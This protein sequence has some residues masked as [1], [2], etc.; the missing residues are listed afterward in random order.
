MNEE[1]DI[2]ITSS[3]ILGN[4]AKSG[5][6]NDIT[7]N[8]E[9]E[10]II[11][12]FLIIEGDRSAD[13]IDNTDFQFSG[14]SLVGVISQ[15]IFN[16][17]GS[18]FVQNAD[19]AN[20]FA[21]TKTIDGVTSGVL[22]RNADGQFLVALNANEA[23]PALD[24]TDARLS[25]SD[26]QTTDLVTDITG[27]PR[28]FDQV[29]LDNGL[30]TVTDIGAVELQT[31]VN[32]TPAS[33]TPGPDVLTGDNGAN[34]ISGLRGADTI[35][36]GGGADT[37]D[38]GGGGDLI[39]GNDGKDVISGGGG[40]DT[41]EGNGGR[42]IIAGGGGKDDLDGGGGRDMV[43]GNGGR[44]TVKGGG[45]NDTLVGG[46][47]NDVL[48][49]GGGRDTFQ[50]TRGDGR[51]TITDFDQLCDK[52]EIID[53]AD[54]FDDLMITQA[55]DDVRIKFANVVITVENDQAENFTAADFI[56]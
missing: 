28:S 5:I 4:V 24:A 38:G 29:G 23:N 55:G 32:V 40:K 47:G 33:P 11:S 10:N 2:R 27:A 26:F 45:G 21:E 50:F 48:T 42:D 20:V 34:T 13:S 43:S 14:K 54:S 31:Q 41:I 17:G 6:H 18:E 25:T 12:D 7:S 49:G 30:L 52:I 56:F 36:G 15:S 3:L 44:N 53:G 35:S 46:K 22:T 19:P 9:P 16:A 39:A 8:R 51:D 1:N 37:L